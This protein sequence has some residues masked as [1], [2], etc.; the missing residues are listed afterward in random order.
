MP[1][2]I[3]VSLV[4]WRTIFSFASSSLTPNSQS[5]VTPEPDQHRLQPPRWNSPV[6]DSRAHAAHRR[7][8]EV[9]LYRFEILDSP[10][11]TG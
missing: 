8:F 2:N 5:T 10:F 11:H 1:M 7:L 3:V 9:K 6:P 4:H